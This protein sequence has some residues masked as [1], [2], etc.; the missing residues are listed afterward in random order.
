M[1]R[2]VASHAW[3]GPPAPPSPP[4]AARPPLLPASPGCPSSLSPSLRRASRR[5]GGASSLPERPDPAARPA[6]DVGSSRGA[7]R[8]AGSSGTASPE[9][10]QDAAAAD[11]L[12]GPVIGSP[13]FFFFLFFYF[14][15]RGG[16]WS[17]SV[18]LG[19]IVM[20]K[21]RRTG[22][23]TSENHFRPPRKTF[24]VVVIS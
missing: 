18:N 9:W 16:K 21:G 12:G 15:N 14:I 17:A 20:V 7:T 6:W 19:F 11:G 3:G 1:V 23:T 2:Q 5:R 8:E 4:S 10:R 22:Q 24:F 13:S